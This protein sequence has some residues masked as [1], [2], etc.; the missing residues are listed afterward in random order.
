MADRNLRVPEVAPSVLGTWTLAV[1]RA[2]DARGVDGRVVASRAGIDVAALDD[3]DCRHPI[4]ATTRL[5]RLAV[6]ATGDPC[7][8]LWASRFVTQTTFH[9]LG[10]A[11]FAS[12]TLHDAFE[13]FVRYG[14]L[15]SDAAEIRLHRVGEGEH[16]RLVLPE[17]Q[18]RPTDEAI[19][20]ILS[21]VARVARMLSDGKVT[22][23]ALQVERPEPVP[24]EPFAKVF[25]APVRF[26]QRENVLQFAA[27]DFDARLPAGNAELARHNDEVV[28]RY[29]ARIERARV[30]TRLRS[31]L[32]DQLPAGEPAEEAAARSL[33]MSLR[34]LQRRLQ[35]EHTTY[36]QALNDTRQQMARAHLEE[37]RTSVSEIAFL[38]GFADTSSFSRAFRRWTGQ[39]PRAYTQHRAC[40]RSTAS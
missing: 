18:G 35:A 40:S 38:L 11:V 9:A 21:L 19:D 28:A 24:S 15:V 3:P 14:H 32:I 27:C 30:C 23:V 13:R 33:G 12:A 7:F 37:G 5:W 22:P 20:A 26:G 4:A 6:E 31:W 2:L 1:V 29:L 10:F 16:F 34:N 36:R 17:G 8:G 25:R 39:S